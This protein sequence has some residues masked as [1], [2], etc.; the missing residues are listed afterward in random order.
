MTGYISLICAP[1]TDPQQV[2]LSRATKCPVLCFLLLQ[3]YI[4]RLEIRFASFQCSS[5]TSN[6]IPFETITEIYPIQPCEKRGMCGQRL[7]Y[8]FRNDQGWKKKRWQETT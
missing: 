7:V 2:P 3:L 4:E 5:R 6:E 1:C 8:L